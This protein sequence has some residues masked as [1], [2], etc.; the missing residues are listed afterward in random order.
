MADSLRLPPRLAAILQDMPLEQLA[1]SPVPVKPRHD[2][3]TPARQAAFILRLALIGCVAAA[4]KAV[5][6]SRES[7]Y[8]LREH[9]GAASF[10]AAW[11]R[12]QGWGRGQAVDLG[13]ERAL[14]GE[15]RGVYYRGRKI[16]EEVRHDNRLIIAALRGLVPEPARAEEDLNATF[17]RLLDEI[18]PQGAARSAAANDFLPRTA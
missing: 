14:L 9:Q 10:A 13:L 18:D 6:K 7:A 8:R 12:A 5:G 11:D 16:A 4:A 3:W 17:R 15:T 1:F 2:G